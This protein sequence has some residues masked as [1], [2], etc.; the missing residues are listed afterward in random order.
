VSFN[1]SLPLD[2][3]TPRFGVGFAFRM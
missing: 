1:A 3:L 2:T